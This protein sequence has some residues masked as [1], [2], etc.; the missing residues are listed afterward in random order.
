MSKA[1]HLLCKL[2]SA[3]NLHVLDSGRVKAWV[4]SETLEERGKLYMW[5]NNVLWNHRGHFQKSLVEC[6]C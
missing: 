1:R 6:H 4:L 5:S 3:K 2:S